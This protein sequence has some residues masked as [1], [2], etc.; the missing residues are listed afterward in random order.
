MRHPGHGVFLLAIAVSL[1]GVSGPLTGAVPG[2][3]PNSL[4]VMS[5]NIREGR[6]NDGNLDLNHV[7]AVI[8]AIDPD[9]V[10]LQEVD[11]NTEGSGFVDQTAVLAS[12][13]QMLYYEFGKARAW[14]R[15]DLGNAILSHYPFEVIAN[16]PLPMN[17]RNE[18]PRAALFVKVDVSSLYGGGET[19]ITVIGTH[20]DHR[21]EASRIQAASFIEAALAELP[22]RD[23]P[24]LLLGDLND[25]PGSPTLDAFNL[26]WTIEDLGQILPT[27]PAEAPTRQLD[28]ALQRSAGDWVTHHVEVPVEPDAS[29]HRPIVYVYEMNTLPRARFTLSC[30]GLACDFTDTSYDANGSIAT[31]W[32]DFGDGQMSTDQQP[33]HAYNEEG[34]YSV[35]LTV[36]DDQ[37]NIAETSRT[38]VID[39][40]PANIVLAT[41][42]Y[43]VRGRMMVDL[44]WTGTTVAEVDIVRD[45][46]VIATPTNI[47]A[48]TDDVN[49]RGGGSFTYQVCEAATSS[50]SNQSVVTF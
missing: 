33:T 42:G 49:R 10:S 1:G 22:D 3:F 40:T 7:A 11:K 29:D 17:K 24:A 6:G 21:Q 47:G 16:H 48:Y 15:G 45:D 31:R 20:L 41:L 5:Y 4:T 13:T 37:L 23:R 8:A 35:R 44:T 12:L 38:V 36:T 28:Y 9:I 14:D 27:F 46:V 43:K 39:V 30:S 25:V 18:E 2:G 19:A 26:F 50:C 32:W 34:S